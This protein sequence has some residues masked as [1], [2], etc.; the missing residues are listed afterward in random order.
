MSSLFGPINPIPD[1]VSYPYNKAWCHNFYWRVRSDKHESSAKATW[2]TIAIIIC[3]ILLEIVVHINFETRDSPVKNTDEEE[4]SSLLPE[5]PPILVSEQPQPE[6]EPHAEPRTVEQAKNENA[7]WN[8]PI[9]TSCCSD[10]SGPHTRATRLAIALILYAITLGTFIARIHAATN[11]P[12]IDYR[13]RPY[14]SIPS[15]NWTAITLL[16]IIPFICATFA[17]LRALVDCVLVRWKSGLVYDFQGDGCPW[18]PCMP[19]FAVVVLVYGAFEALKVPIACIMG[20]WEMS[21]WTRG[22]SKKG[23]EE[24]G[25]DDGE[26]GR[27]DGLPAYDEIVGS[28]RDRNGGSDGRKGDGEGLV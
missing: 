12:H 20:D 19:F 14:L 4:A 18:V 24:V 22:A 2:C 3:A 13:C 26:A 25:E 27:E 16:N 7:K 9:F 17:F 1:D 6:S 11:H 10:S 15:P 28:E 23:R 21:I 5:D 8:K